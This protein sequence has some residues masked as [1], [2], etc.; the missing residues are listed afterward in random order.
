M[1]AM[2][3]RR[4]GYDKG[5]TLNVWQMTLVVHVSALDCRECLGS[6]GWAEWC[7]VWFVAWGISPIGP[8]SQCLHLIA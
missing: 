2:V 1:E 4:E 5:E 3:M 6:G 8:Q 7:K